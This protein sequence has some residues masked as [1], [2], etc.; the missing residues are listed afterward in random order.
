MIAQSEKIGRAKGK[1]GPRSND[2]LFKFY[3]LINNGLTAAQRLAQ[4][5]L[6]NY[7]HLNSFKFN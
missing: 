1:K 3:F 7:Y 2:T 5:N 4:I 6:K